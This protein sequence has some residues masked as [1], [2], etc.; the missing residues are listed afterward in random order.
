METLQTNVNKLTFTEK[1]DLIINQQ[2]F[3]ESGNFRIGKIIKVT[4]D[5]VVECDFDK[6]HLQVTK[7]D[8]SFPSMLRGT[9]HVGQTAQV[10]RTTNSGCTL[11]SI[12]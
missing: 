9:L 10:Y 6:I 3:I 2:T 1:Q 5:I 8:I 4:P 11:Y 7:F 12:K